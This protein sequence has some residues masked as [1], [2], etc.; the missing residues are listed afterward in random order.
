MN[1]IACSI[2]GCTLPGIAAPSVEFLPPASYNYKG[3][4]VTA[5]LPDLLHCEQHRDAATAED[6]RWLYDQ[7]LQRT[8]LAIDFAR[9]RVR[10]MDV[11]SD[12]WRETKERMP[13]GRAVN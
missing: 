12:E 10:W 11:D 7:I 5:N 6:F 13:L 9:T 8:K 3:K 4:P 2:K 1:V